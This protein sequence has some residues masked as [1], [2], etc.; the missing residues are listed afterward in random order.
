MRSK[1]LCPNCRHWFLPNPKAGSRQRFC[2]NPQCQ[3]ERHRRDCADWRSRNP[4]YDREDRV[5]R[6]LIRETDDEAQSPPSCAP[7]DRIDWEAARDA[8]G[9]EVAILI[10]ETGKALL[11][12]T[13]D[14]VIGQPIGIKEESAKHSQAC[15]RDEMECGRQGGLA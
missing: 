7:L 8:V 6:K 3:R 12:G 1:Q 4:Y 9:L 11:E 13:R 14:S 15:P 2:S 5:R 10:E